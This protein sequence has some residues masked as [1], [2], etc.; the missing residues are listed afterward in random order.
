M[1]NSVFNHKGFHILVS[2]KEIEKLAQER[3]ILNI[4]SIVTSEN[5]NSSSFH[6]KNG[7]VLEGT[8]QILL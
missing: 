7:F 5:D 6:L 1:K 2:S 3:G 8:I 4:I